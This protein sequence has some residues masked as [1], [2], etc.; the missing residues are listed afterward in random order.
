MKE[1]YP[2]AEIFCLTYQENNHANT[3]AA[4][5]KRF[6]TSVT[7]IAEYFGATVVDQSKDAITQSNCHAYAHDSN[8]LHPTAA[9]HAIMAENI[10]KTMYEK[11]KN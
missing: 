11:A 2:D 1:L 9:G 8:S 5:L 4:K 3:T 7:A 6:S 10:I